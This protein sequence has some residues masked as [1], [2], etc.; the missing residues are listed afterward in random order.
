[1]RKKS[2]IL[3]ARY[4]AD[5][6]NEAESLQEHRKAFCVG[7]ILPDLRPSFF[8]R[9]H[10]YSATIEDLQEKIRE[11]AQFREKSCNG[12]VYWRKFGEVIH[13]I[14]DYFTFPH[15]Q[16]YTGNFFQHNQYEK[17]LKN[18]LKQIIKSDHIQNYQ[19]EAIC[20]DDFSDLM[21]Y[22][23]NVHKIYLKKERSILEDV[24]YILTVCYQVIQGIF[25]LFLESRNMR[26]SLSG[27]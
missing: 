4:L 9:K 11:L 12:R 16:T 13:Y 14:A 24:H 22:I 19:N 6:M 21:N 23:K 10:E 8:T 5:Q 25:A 27:M 2:H 3:L 17:E 26:V 7:S 1:M 20:F 15:N 18:T